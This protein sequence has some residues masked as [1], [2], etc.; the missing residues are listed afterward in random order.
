MLTVNSFS[1][2]VYMLLSCDVLT[3]GQSKFSG[4]LL[5]RSVSDSLKLPAEQ[6]HAS[7]VDTPCAFVMRMVLWVRQSVRKSPFE[8]AEKR[9]GLGS[10]LRCGEVGRPAAALHFVSG[11]H[12]AVRYLLRSGT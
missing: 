4:H 3:V 12:V 9:T 2:H 8:T 11:L 10:Q 6:I 7:F 1:R 5:Q